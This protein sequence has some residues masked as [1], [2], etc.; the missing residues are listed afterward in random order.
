MLLAEYAALMA[1]RQTPDSALLWLRACDGAPARRCTI[2]APAQSF[3]LF[4]WRMGGLLLVGDDCAVFCSCL[5]LYGWLLVAA[6]ACERDASRL[7]DADARVQVWR[8]VLE[9]NQQ[10]LAGFDVCCLRVFV[11]VEASMRA[12]ASE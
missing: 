6:C 12:C 11:F 4:F 1:L 10:V 8:L 3:A 7:R 9:R 2:D 5:C